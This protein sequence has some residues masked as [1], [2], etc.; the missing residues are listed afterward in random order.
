MT[1]NLD[2]AL[3]PH[4]DA[5]EWRA[6]R[7]RILAS[8]LANADTPGY[9]A[10][11]LDFKAIMKAAETGSREQLELARREPG[12]LGTPAPT[13][14]DVAEFTRWRVPVNPSID[15]NTVDTQLEQADFARNALQFQ[16]ALTFLSGRLRGLVN[17]FRGE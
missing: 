4:P 3:G 9:Q 7:T 12:H 6:A 10:R 13:R 14:P 11:D 1:I 5:L 8:N 17:A 2:N 15:G 16:A